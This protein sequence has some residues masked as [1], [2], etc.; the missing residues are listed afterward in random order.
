MV[1]L[2]SINWRPQLRGSGRDN[3]P[4]H[5]P[6]CSCNLV[7]ARAAGGDAKAISACTKLIE[8]WQCYV[9]MRELD[10]VE[11]PTIKCVLC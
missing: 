8:H 2:M 3:I 4:I 10:R 1:E 9:S 11:L 7:G 5:V 6:H